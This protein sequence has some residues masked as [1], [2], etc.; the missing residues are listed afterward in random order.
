MQSIEDY[1][2]VVHLKDGEV[3]GFVS[4]TAWFQIP[5]LMR[6]FITNLNVVQ[7]TD[8]YTFYVATYGTM[9][10]YH[11]EDARRTLAKKGI[12]LDASF[13]VRQPDTWTPIFD[14][15]DPVAVARTNEKA[16]AEI[17]EL[18]VK[19]QNRIQGNHT[20]RRWPYFIHPVTEWLLN[21]QSQTKHFYVEDSC[22]GCGLCARR[23]PEHAITIKDK[24]PVWTKSNA[25]SAYVACTIVPSSPFN[26]ATER[27][28]NMVS[29]ATLIQ[30]YK[31]YGN[32]ITSYSKRMLLA[33]WIFETTKLG[34]KRASTEIKKVARFITNTHSHENCTGATST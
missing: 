9:P 8:N 29:T 34:S 26:M 5:P 17:R 21:R 22:I 4:Y 30:K 14:L 23:C 19:V 6:E 20:S 24:R 3:L 25:A 33:G 31:I 13:S 11:G 10:G 28:S 15:S 18:V 1:S 12:R 27:P 16:E 7:A 32:H 2:Q